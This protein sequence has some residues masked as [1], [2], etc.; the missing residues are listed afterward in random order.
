MKPIVNPMHDE[1]ITTPFAHDHGVITIP[2]GP[3]LGVEVIESVLE[4]Y[5][6]S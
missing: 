4:H 6:L 1:L 3:G 5:R 2:D